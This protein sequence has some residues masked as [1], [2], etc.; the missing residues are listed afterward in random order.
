MNE[1]R[2]KPPRREFLHQAGTATLMAM[3]P[4]TVRAAVH[5]DGSDAPEVTGLR[6]GIMPLSDCASVVV[7]AAMG[8]DRKHGIRIHPVREASWASLRDKLLCG[9]L[10]AAQMLYGL[11]YGVQTGIGGVQRDMAVLMNLNVN[12][13]GISLSRNIADRGV[14]GLESLAALIRREP[15]RHVLAHTFPTGT[16]ALWL[17]YWLAA[18]GIDPMR[19]IRS[20]VV[21]PQQMVQDASAGHMIGFSVGEPWNQMGIVSGVSVH[22][23]SS[24]DIW[25]DHPEKVLGTTAEFAK[26][27]PHASRALIKAVLEAGRWIDASEENRRHAAE[28]IAAAEFVNAPADVIA[29]RMTGQYDNGLGKRWHDPRHLKFFG[30]GT[31][32]FPYLSDG[33][34]FLTQHRRW[35][36]LKSDPDYAGIASAVNRVDLYSEAAAALG[37]PVPASAF[38]KATLFDGVTWDGSRPAEYATRTPHAVLS[39]LPLENPRV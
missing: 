20:I 15:G 21:P 29:G 19:D 35:G 7:A 11:A 28:I 31:V 6:V 13:Q 8:F 17:N 4:G 34:W 23:A 3:L 25:P 30:D 14:T 16:H 32:N 12:G 1:Y 37:I 33:I 27:H 24:Q 5:V 26:Q 36:L 18:A 10:D 38:R 9:Q 39:S 2:Q 22:A